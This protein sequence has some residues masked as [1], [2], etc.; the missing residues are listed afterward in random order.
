MALLD[1]MK[2]AQGKPIVGYAE[3][4]RSC[5]P[6]SVIL[7]CFFEAKE[8]EL[9]YSNVIYSIIGEE[10]E[11]FRC[12][13]KKG[14]IRVY[15][16]VKSNAIYNEIKTAFFVDKDF[17]PL[18][19]NPEIFETPYHSIENFFVV[20]RSV[21]RAFQQ[22]F[23]IHPTRDEEDFLFCTKLYVD[24]LNEFHEKVLHLNAWLSCHADERQKGNKIK[25]YIDQRIK[26]GEIV[27]NDL[28]RILIE[29]MSFEE[30]NQVFETDGIVEEAFNQK[31]LMFRE[32]NPV[33]TFRGK[34]ELQFLASFLKQFRNEVSK[35][36]G[37]ICNKRYTTTLQF[38]IENILN[39]LNSCAFIPQDL[40]D[41]IERVAA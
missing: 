16:L 25:L 31:V 22:H 34:F 30:I 12:D 24:L 11:T 38:T 9:Y 5:K 40:R 10:F 14:V 1:E 18:L 21:K 33:E 39:T 6:A 26:W 28:S 4:L 41:Y 17:D 7:H 2:E 32:V 35:R 37:H 36:N 13:D 3:F 15:Q 8:D 23:G 20:V 27:S 29:S 19:N